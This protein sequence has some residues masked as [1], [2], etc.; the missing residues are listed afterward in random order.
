MS[1]SLLRVPKKAALTALRGLFVGTSC[2]LVLITEDRRRR[3][4]QAR[5]AVRNAERIRS[6]KQYH[7]APPAFDDIQSS[8]ER[9]CFDDVSD[10]AISIEPD[11]RRLRTQ[12]RNSNGALDHGQVESRRS[13]QGAVVERPKDMLNSCADVPAES[14]SRQHGRQGATDNAQL[15]QVQHGFV[16]NSE[17]AG[18]SRLTWERRSPRAWGAHA[19]FPIP[20][21]SPELFKRPLP[22]TSRP[23][24]SA[25]E[26]LPH[27]SSHNIDVHENVRWVSEAV[28]LGDSSS[29]VEAVN[30]LS[31]TLRKR[32]MAAEE[33]RALI[34]A[35]ASLCSKCQESGMMDDAARAL[36]MVVQLGPLPEADYY[37][38]NPQPLIDRAISAAEVEVDKLKAEGEKS[39]RRERLSVGC[40]LERVIQ[41]LLPRFTEIT[42]SASRLQEWLPAAEKSMELALDLHVLTESAANVYWRIQH[43]GGDPDGLVTRRFMEGLAQQAKHNRILNTF[44]LR[45]YKLAQYKPET[46]YA[47]GNLV[48]DALEL[49]PGKDP[50][51][52]LKTM[53]QFCPGET[54]SPERP[55]RTTW[56]T[57][58]LYCHWQRMSTFESTLALFREFEGLGGFDKVVHLDG[59]YRVMIQIAVEAERWTDVDDLLKQLEVVKPSTAKEARILG[60]LALAKAKLGDW[61][62]VW[63]DFKKMEIRYLVENVFA[64]VLHEFIKTHTTRETEDFLRAYIEDLDIPISP[65]MVNMVANRYGDVRDAHS[66][67]EWLAYCSKKGFEVDAAFGNAILTNCR[68]RW[69]FSFLDLKLI[70]RTLAMLNPNFVDNVTENDMISAVLRTHRRAKPLFVK[71]EIALVGAKSHTWGK[72]TSPD[73]MRIDLRHAFVTRKYKQALHLYKSACKRGVPVDDGHLRIAVKAS[74]KLDDRIQPALSLIKEGKAKGIDVSTA[75]TQVFLTQIHHVFGGDTSDKED[76]LRQVRDVIAR[77][78]ESGLS[79]GHQPMLRVAYLL[80][81]AGHFQSAISFGLSALQR[82]GISYPDDVPTFQLLFLAYA[83]KS[84]VQG[85]KW[86]IAGAVHMQYYHK[87]SVFKVL[88]DARALLRKQIQTSDVKEALWVVEQGLDKVR[89]QRLKNIEERKGLESGIIEIMKHAA[90]EAE[91]QPDSEAMRRRDEILQELDAK[92][93][94]E[95]VIAEREEAARRSERQARYQAALELKLKD[96]EQ[97]ETM[98]AILLGSRHDIPTVF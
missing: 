60:L 93:R 70:H 12:I 95:E 20:Q 32:D 35:A 45:R 3:I 62:G 84:D 44:H 89:L 94:Q 31:D 74:L 90:L 82:K 72:L 30:V 71:K 73:D 91:L 17:P 85:M 57:K 83:Y 47:I 66:F 86:T 88:K 18:H 79:L 10:A 54:L 22:T 24:P 43:Y 16:A 2:T 75:I 38:C 87:K 64:P 21:P 13:D 39:H 34:H 26:D 49:T 29:L 6:S 33:K 51:R 46:W 19:V 40:K 9:K 65:Y 68:R 63:T 81:Q 97:A 96:Q 11:E 92:A 14:A 36:Y 4:N 28:A 50:S 77:F 42:L 8:A 98:E 53:L 41:L 5:S 1:F 58:L 69:D 80:L 27:P 59:P 67:V 37:A 48:T 15:R 76:T 55:L 23:R 56:V 52:L 25:T 7:A 78:E 61:N